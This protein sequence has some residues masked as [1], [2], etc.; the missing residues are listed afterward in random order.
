MP[1][2]FLRLDFGN[3]TFRLFARSNPPAN[4]AA[5]TQLTFNGTFTTTGLPSFPALTLPSFPALTLPSD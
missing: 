3:Q 2:F 4:A 1:R 5:A